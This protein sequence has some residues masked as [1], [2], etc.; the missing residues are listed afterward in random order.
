MIVKATKL[1]LEEKKTPNNWG[2]IERNEDHA[3][4]ESDMKHVR[5]IY[6]KDVVD[7][8]ESIFDDNGNFLLYD[9]EI[10]RALMVQIQNEDEFNKRY[11]G[12]TKKKRYTFDTQYLKDIEEYNYTEDNTKLDTNATKLKFID[13]DD[14]LIDKDYEDMHALWY[15]SQQNEKLGLDGF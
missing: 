12:N 9:I 4:C 5:T 8:T 2:V 13:R 15:E 6:Y 7:D 14:V 3:V 1:T 10:L 11:T